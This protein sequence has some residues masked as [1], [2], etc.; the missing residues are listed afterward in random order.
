MI[1][2]PCPRAV[3]IRCSVFQ[4][5]ARS[6][7]VT[8]KSFCQ[9]LNVATVG[10]SRAKGGAAAGELL[11]AR[12]LVPGGGCSQKLDLN[13]PREANDVLQ[14]ISLGIGNVHA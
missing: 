8:E 11:H 7:T 14:V 5:F 10:L 1:V 12:D 2:K 13:P 6:I 9:R 3:E 4:N